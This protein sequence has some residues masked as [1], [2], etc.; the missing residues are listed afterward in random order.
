[1]RIIP[2]LQRDAIAAALALGVLAGPARAQSSADSAAVVQTVL[3][4]HEALAR[5][6]SADALAR[7]APDVVIIEGGRTETLD[8]YRSGHLRGDMAFARAMSRTTSDVRVVQV[9]DV[10]WATSE[11][12]VQGTMRGRQVDS[13]SAELMVLSRENGAWRIRAIHWSS[14]RRP[15]R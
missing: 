8:H 11:S 14:R 1:M 6:D 10:A 15:A 4:F 5:G 2:I 13:R 7:L 12:R 9:D 3:G